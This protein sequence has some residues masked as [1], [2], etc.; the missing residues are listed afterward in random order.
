MASLRHILGN[1]HSVGIHI[2]YWGIFGISFAYIGHQGPIFSISWAY[3]DVVYT[4]DIGYINDIVYTDDMVYTVDLIYT[5]DKVYT[6][7]VF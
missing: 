4:V 6:V 1:G 3:L 2:L 7:D 5:V